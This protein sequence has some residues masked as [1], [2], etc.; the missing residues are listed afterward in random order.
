MA[1]LYQGRG[2]SGGP[3]VPLQPPPLPPPLPPN[4]HTAYP[5]D[6]SGGHPFAG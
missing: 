1:N 4:Q 6:W 3:G 5:P 2:G